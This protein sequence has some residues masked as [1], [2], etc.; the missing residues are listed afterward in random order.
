MLKTLRWKLTFFYFIIALCLIALVGGGA[1]W[2]LSRYFQQTTDMALQYRMAQ[3]LSRYGVHMPSDMAST[4]A[5]WCERNHLPTPL[6]QTNIGENAEYE[7]NDEDEWYEDEAYNADLATIFVFPLD[8][9]GAMLFDPNPVSP[10]VAPV[11]DAVLSASVNGCDWRTVNLDDGRALRLF[12][13]SLPP[14]T[15]PQVLQVGRFMEYSRSVLRT[16][17]VG[18]LGLAGFSTFVLGFGAWYLAG[19]S[20][21]PAQRA[22]DQQQAFIANASHELR[23]PLTIIRAT[24]EVAMRHTEIEKQKALLH[25]LVDEIDHMASLVEDLLLLSRLD[26]GKLILEKEDVSIDELVNGIIH[27]SQSLM[28]S[29]G[30]VIDQTIQPILVFADQTRLR[31]VLLIL[32]INAI[33]HTPVG[34]KIHISADTD[35]KGITLVV[36]DTGEGIS[37]DH[38]PHVFERFYQGDSTMQQDYRGSG[39][40]LS[41]AKSLVEAHGGSISIQSKERVGTQVTILLPAKKQ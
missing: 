31:Q 16:L 37:S 26:A 5:R 25:G 12:T 24:A 19:R 39:L 36:E 11:V 2:M 21:K 6:I 1:Y 23:A 30:I 20:L 35:P 13:Y 32:L 22:F 10:R 4:T 28:E 14:N 29:K 41:I 33:H 38:L 34:G 9:D 18:I 7:D 17:M 15:A 27:S 8:K 40:G 3:E